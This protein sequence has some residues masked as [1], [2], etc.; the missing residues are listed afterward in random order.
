MKKLPILLTTGAA[1]VAVSLA[2]RVVQ[3]ERRL[4]AGEN[5]QDPGS[6]PL[7]VRKQ[8]GDIAPTSEPAPAGTVPLEA[9]A[10][11]LASARAEVAELK[12]QIRANQ[13]RPNPGQTPDLTNG[14]I[15]DAPLNTAFIPAEKTAIEHW[16]G[17]EKRR[18]G[19]EQA[20]GAPDTGQPGDIPTAWASKS[21][22]GGKEWL[23]L[24]Y[25]RFVDLQQI[26]VVESHNPGAISKVVAVLSNGREAPVWE[27][28]MD[29]SASDELVS[30]AFPVAESLRARSVKVY[31]D[32]TR[33]PG[34]NEIDAVEVVG[35][36]GKKQWATASR[37]SSSYADP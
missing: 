23:Q 22:D 31:L 33:V 7:P 1:L 20:V 24:D 2:S 34:W 6:R 4:A 27:G 13:Q 17:G 8:A 32:T 18:W 10:A 15:A 36:D 29:P 14:S 11:E 26:N 5:R 25:D 37:A 30:S 3:L 19:H 21:P 16:T 9:L 28:T 12:Q 35:R